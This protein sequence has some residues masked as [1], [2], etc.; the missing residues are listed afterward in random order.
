MI[1]A[2][3]SINQ[4]AEVGRGHAGPEAAAG[5]ARWF[6]ESAIRIRPLM[7]EGQMRAIL[8][9]AGA[10]SIGGPVRHGAK[11]GRTIGFPTANIALG[12]FSRP[13]AGI[14]ASISLLDDGRLFSSLSYVG[15][16]PTFDDGDGRLEVFLFDVDEDIYGR[17]L[18]TV[19]IA[20]LR[21][22]ERFASLE[23]MQRQMRRDRMAGRPIAFRALQSIHASGA[24]SRSRPGSS[25]LRYASR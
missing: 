9:R 10:R 22:D 7:F 2:L 18:E 25:S 14:Y 11:L 24:R 12:D 15:G 16:R 8:S 4:I 23:A 17:R 6:S 20:F 3:D 13:Q 5:C 19:L 1:S 21:P